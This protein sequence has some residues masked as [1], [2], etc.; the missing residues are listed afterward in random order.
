M[1]EPENDRK[2]YRVF[3]GNQNNFLRGG[4]IYHKPRTSKHCFQCCAQ[5]T[6]S[7]AILHPIFLS[8]NLMLSLSYRPA[9]KKSSPA[10]SRAEILLGSVPSFALRA[11]GGQARTLL[12]VSLPNHSNRFGRPIV[13]DRRSR[14]TNFYCASF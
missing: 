12:V 5:K 6:F 7:L 10:E 11:T 8:K 9:R 1:T 14:K 4:F 13:H 3:A 2:N